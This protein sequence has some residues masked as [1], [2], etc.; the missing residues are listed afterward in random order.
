MNNIIFSSLEYRIYTEEDHLLNNTYNLLLRFY[1]IRQCEAGH[2]TSWTWF[3]CVTM[4]IY[5]S[6][7]IYYY[8]DTIYAELEELSEVS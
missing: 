7:L 6:P 3:A 8:I 1:L 4:S 5:D 2:G